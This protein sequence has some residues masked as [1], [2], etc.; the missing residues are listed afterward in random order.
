MQLQIHC[1]VYTNVQNCGYIYIYIYIS[2]EDL[3]MHAD[4]GKK[5]DSYSA[6]GLKE[7]SLKWRHLNF[8]LLYWSVG[9]YCT[10]SDCIKL[11]KKAFD[12][13]NVGEILT[14]H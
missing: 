3:G 10:Q 14:N 4:K 9:R 6:Y 12:L 2:L 13:G 11:P 8:K 7:L 5:F 1:Q